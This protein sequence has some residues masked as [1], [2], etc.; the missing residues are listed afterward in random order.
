MCESAFGFSI[1]FHC[2]IYIFSICP[3]TS[4]QSL[5]SN[6]VLNSKDYF[7]YF[8]PFIF[9]Y[10]FNNTLANL[11]THTHTHTHTLLDFAVGEM[12]LNL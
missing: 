3:N 11:H 12:A 7:A 5:S 8:L 1:W 6:F 9:T 2:S 10:I 4:K